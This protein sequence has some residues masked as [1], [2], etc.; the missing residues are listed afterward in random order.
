M[1][2]D[3]LQLFNTAL[4]DTIV[5]RSDDELW[6]FYLE[7]E[8]RIKMLTDINNDKRP[9]YPKTSILYGY[10]HGL[11]NF[12]KLFLD[13]I[14]DYRQDIIFTTVIDFCFKDEKVWLEYYAQGGF[15]DNGSSC[16]VKTSDEI[17]PKVWEESEAAAYAQYFHLLEPHH[18]TNIIQAMEKNFDK[19]EKNTREDIDKIKEM[20]KF[21]LKNK[22]YNAAYIF[23][24]I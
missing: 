5:S 17:M 23:S 1:R 19:L 22:G 24:H 8:E 21:C 15:L 2:Y 20:R 12:R 4:V 6:S 16:D 10:P 18:L 13:E 14:E 9:A 3:H 7:N 11:E